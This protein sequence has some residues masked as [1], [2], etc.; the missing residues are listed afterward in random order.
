MK[1]KNKPMQ[2]LQ[3]D[4]I[5]IEGVV[6]TAIGRL[7]FYQERAPSRENAIALTHLETALMWFQKGAQD[8]LNPRS[9]T[10]LFELGAV[11]AES[12]Q[13][14]RRLADTLH[15][16]RRG[17]KGVWDTNDVLVKYDQIVKLWPANTINILVRRL[18]G[19]P[20]QHVIT[21]R[22][23]SGTV[24]FN[25]LKDLHGE[26]EEAEYE[27]KFAD[28]HS[29][30]FRG[31]GRIGLPS[32]AAPPPPS[33]SYDGMR[34]DI[35][36]HELLR[37]DVRSGLKT[38]LVQARQ[39]WGGEKLTLDQ[40]AVRLMVGV[41]DIARIARD[42]GAGSRM[43]GDPG[44]WR[45]EL[46]KELGNVLFSTIRWIDDLGLDPMECLDLAIEA[47]EAFAKS[48]RPR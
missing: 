35:R 47:Q 14:N 22:P 10:A 11:D 27:I 32:G 16:R 46:K 9:G 30:Q 28:V 20:V 1:G 4:R 3:D 12:V 2:Y 41:G 33:T 23:A 29:R 24:L 13:D 34:A 6:Q 40:I 39:I 7:Q 37:E 21:S 45:N 44:P 38:L 17:E 25:K 26:H 8:P 42:H 36:E 15:K 18:T 5:L 19:I 48:G 43:G 31:M